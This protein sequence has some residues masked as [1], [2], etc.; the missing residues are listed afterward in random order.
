MRTWDWICNEF[1]DQGDLLDYFLASWLPVK[2]QW[3]QCYTKKYLNFNQNV[4][5]QTEASNFKIKSYL[6]SGKCD[7]LRLAKALKE[8]CEN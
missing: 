3:V 1:R 8:L 7:W 5:T 4:T 2:Y 6:V